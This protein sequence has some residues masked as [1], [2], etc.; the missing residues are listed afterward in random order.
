M[1]PLDATRILDLTRLLPGAICT[2][3]LH[4]LGAEIIKIED[5]QQGDYAR[6]MPPL[7]D[8]MGAF[9]RSSNRGK[10]SVIL[11]LK[12]PAGQAVLHRLVQ[13]ADVLIEGFRPGVTARLAADYQ[14]LQ[15]INPRL[16]YSSL[17]GWGQSGP[18]ASASG[19]DLNYIARNGVLGAE[20][21]PQTPASQAAD[22]AGSYVAVM[23]ILAALLNRTQ[24]G[25]GDYVDVSLAEAAMPFAMAAWMESILPSAQD[26]VL[27]LSGCSACYRVYYAADGKPV[28]LGAIEGKFW[29]NFCNAMEK[30]QWI[31]QHT[32]PE[33]QPELIEEVAA[34]FETKKAAEWANLLEDA[35]C[36]FSRVTMPE[37]LLGDTHWQARGMVG[38]NQ[39]G[40]PWMRSPVRLSDDAIDISAAPQYGEHTQ[41]V[42][43]DCGFSAAEID[44][45]LE[46]GVICQSA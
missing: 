45:L 19:H 42:L 18:L 17:S 35:D 46:N 11:N 14:T 26:S 9:F 38:M 15:A 41:A 2:M 30:P 36:C 20:Q 24:T 33:R 25:T 28:V 23:G 1:T 22:V 13:D 5:P 10:K 4:D 39:D 40:L 7:I 31:E 27:S 8:G 16:V 21:N 29:A 34:L 6:W 43:Q 37:H 32:L 12:D 3:M 44:K